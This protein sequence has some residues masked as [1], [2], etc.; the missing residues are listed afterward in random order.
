MTATLTEAEMTEVLQ[1]LF[2]STGAPPACAL[3]RYL[4]VPVPV[5]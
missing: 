5:T 4:T 2:A 1:R 3:G